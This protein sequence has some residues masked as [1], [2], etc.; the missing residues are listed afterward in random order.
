MIRLVAD[1]LHTLNLMEK[2]IKW[3]WIDEFYKHIDSVTHIF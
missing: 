1:V 2:Q 3:R